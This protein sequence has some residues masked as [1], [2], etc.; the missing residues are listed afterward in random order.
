MYIKSAKI[1]DDG[2]KFNVKKWV[3]VT[4]ILYS[5]I[6]E[7]MENSSPG[8]VIAKR[9]KRAKKTI[10]E[11]IAEGRKDWA[12][13]EVV[14]RNREMQRGTEEEKRKR[15]ELARNKRE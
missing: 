4:E 7:H 11:V 10:L 5:Q 12:A 14:E 9:E 6:D 8:I 13:R 3:E 2:H 15:E 1:E